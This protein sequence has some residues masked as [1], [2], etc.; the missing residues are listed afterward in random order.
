MIEQLK[1]SNLSTIIRIGL[2]IGMR[3]GIREWLK[4]WC[5]FASIEWRLQLLDSI[6]VRIQ[7]CGKV[8]GWTK[9]KRGCY[10]KFEFCFGISVFFGSKNRDWTIKRFLFGFFVVVLVFVLLLLLFFVSVLIWRI[11]EN[12]NETKRKKM[13]RSKKGNV[14]T[15]RRHSRVVT[16]RTFSFGLYSSTKIQR[17]YIHSLN[18]T[19]MFHSEIRRRKRKKEETDYKL[20]SKEMKLSQNYK[21]QTKPNQISRTA[22]K[23][24]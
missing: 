11:F 2:R 8:F 6:N 20:T 5:C 23:K 9:R 21:I 12:V 4:R 10:V 16:A 7:L 24:K 13:V 15:K 3:I 22:T 17:N 19:V 14:K 18:P 1:W